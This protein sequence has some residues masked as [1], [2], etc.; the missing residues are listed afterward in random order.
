MKRSHLLLAGSLITV[1]VMVGSSLPGT[2]IAGQA[3]VAEK[4][5]ESR[6]EKWAEKFP[7]QFKTWMQ[8]SENDTITDMLEKKPQLAVLWAGYG[9][10]KDY[11]APRGHFY[12]V[13]S[14]INSLRTGAPVGPATGPMPTACWTCKS[15]D[16]PRLIEEQGEL[17]YF[18]GKWAK[19]GNEMAN[20]IGC[21]DCHS[22]QTA[23]LTIS[24][25][26]LER[27]LEAIGVDTKNIDS[28]SMRSL[29]CAQCHS[30]YYFKATE[31]TDKKGEKKVAKV[32]TLPWD[33]GLTA[34]DMEKYYDEL[35]FKD[36][37]HKISKAPMLKAQHPGYEIFSTGIHAKSGVSCADC[38]MPS[39]TEGDETFSDHHIA[40]PMENIETVCLGCHDQEAEELKAVI[41]TKFERKEQLM[42]IAMDSIAKAHLEAGK[43]WE[44]G[45]T[46][47]EMKEILTDIRHAQWKWDYAIASHGSFFHAPEETLRLLAVANE[48]AQTAR[49]KLVQVLAKHGAVDFIAPDFSDKTK[50]QALAQV[51]LAKL[52]EEKENFRATLLKEWEKQATAKGLLD[53]ATR[54]GMSD[55]TSY[56]K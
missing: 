43:A 37:T 18:T 12:A 5:V 24:R 32:V 38:H 52:V 33:N 41:E 34:E 1:G 14:N 45:A 6:N 17:E 25:P 49:L 26:Y 55:K 31:W 9:F 13:Q 22:S 36:W 2:V 42:E 51:P 28:E 3:G 30:E 54:K 7:N 29:A 11:N 21:A 23:E 44:I 46:E 50:A 48:T 20:A 39:T 35:G 8:T 16:V 40:S 27:G 53:P 19:Y 56:M 10:A 47:T 4:G 15:P